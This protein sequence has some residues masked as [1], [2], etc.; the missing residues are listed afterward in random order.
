M[1]YTERFTE[2]HVPLV[3][4][5]ADSIGISTVDSAWVNL[6][7]YHRVILVVNV[8]DMV[9]GATLDVSI[10]QATTVA[11]AGAKAITGKA[12]TQLTQAGGDSDSLV[13]IELQTEELDVTGSFD[14]VSVRR[15]IAGAAVEMSFVL[16]G[17]VSRYEPVPVTAWTEVIP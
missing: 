11:G 7:N 14:C 16:Y 5:Y 12:I 17:I 2:A 15:V 10:R 3:Y 9:Q 13:S 8:G 4:D 1:T 6:A